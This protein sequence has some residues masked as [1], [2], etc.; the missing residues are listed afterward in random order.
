MKIYLVGG[1]VRDQLLGLPIKERDWVVVGA[2]PQDMLKL[3][4][5]QVGKDFPVFLHPKTHEEYALARLERKVGLGYT[6]FTFD[7]SLDVSLEDDL[8]RRD[9]TINAIAK[10][11]AGELVDPYH[12]QQDI[13]KKLL[14]HVSDAFIEDP[15]RILRVAR[16]AAR[17][18]SFGFSVAPETIQLMKNMV[19]LGEVDA[20]VAERVWKEFE[21]A[22][23]EDHPEKFFE[24]LES[25][26]AR[27]ILFPNLESLDA[28]KKAVSIT[29]ESLIRFVALFA[30]HTEEQIKSICIRYRVPSDYKELASL[31][32]RYLSDYQRVKQLTPEEVLAVLQSTDAFRREA[33]FFNF[34]QACFVCSDQSQELVWQSYYH[35]AKAV[36]IKDL[37][38][39]P[40]KEIANAISL[41]RKE[42]IKKIL[43]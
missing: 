19:E 13:E 32:I 1:A 28:L 41:R 30:Q 18:A 3:G 9:L 40:G 7:T 10:S 34:L 33:R 27:K 5:Q 4:Y 6:G 14:R 21:R 12:G 26:G 23:S 11:E 31:V 15:V 17:F 36:E 22:L 25:C 38:S 39:L 24:T 20:L 8:K 37:L 35:A 16:F 2:T 29:Q 42:A 43:S